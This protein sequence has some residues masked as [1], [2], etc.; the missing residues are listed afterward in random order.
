MVLGCNRTGR[1]RKG[2]I[3]V[4]YKPSDR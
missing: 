1:K 3:L 4:Y 2:K